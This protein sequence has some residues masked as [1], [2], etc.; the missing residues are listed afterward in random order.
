VTDWISFDSPLGSKLLG[1]KKG[2]EFDLN[3]MV[4]KIL[5]IMPGDFK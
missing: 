1:K 4:V 2:D 5:Q 3:S